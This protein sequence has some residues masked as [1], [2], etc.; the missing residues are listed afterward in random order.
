M[1][2]K[3]ICEMCQAYCGNNAC[4]DVWDCAVIIKENS[5]CKGFIRKDATTARDLTKREHFAFELLKIFI[6]QEERKPSLTSMMRYQN[7]N[8]ENQRI[9]RDRLISKAAY[10]AD[11]LIKALNEGKE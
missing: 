7:Q 8:E 5:G 6:D 11:E 1:S 9:I 4:S 10:Y 2:D 3:N